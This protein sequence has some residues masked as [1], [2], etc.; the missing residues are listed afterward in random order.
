MAYAFHRRGDR[1]VARLDAFERANLR[2]LFAQTRLVLAPDPEPESAAESDEFAAMMA[3]MGMP[4]PSPPSPARVEPAAAGRDP[5]L[6]RLLPRAHRGDDEI[7][8]EFRRLAEPGLRR[9]K[10]GNLDVAIA[11]LT[12]PAAQTAGQPGADETDA[13][14]GAHGDLIDLDAGQARA[15]VMALT[16]VR[17]LIGERLGLRTEEDVVAFEEAARIA[18][19]DDPIVV[20]AAWYDFLTWLQETL[21]QAL[22]GPAPGR[23]H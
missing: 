12:L 16:D 9:L 11:A 2:G 17:L 18:E 4:D 8:A 1:F 7:A 13:E 3:Q 6:G 23:D 21:A 5:A 19:P 15:F 20:A 10:T 14:D 22:M